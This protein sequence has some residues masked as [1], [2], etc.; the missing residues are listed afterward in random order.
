MSLC[1]SIQP[2]ILPPAPP[3][4]P[5]PHTSTWTCFGIVI[6]F[7][8]TL[9]F[10]IFMVLPKCCLRNLVTAFQNYFSSFFPFSQTIGFKALSILNP[11]YSTWTLNSKFNRYKSRFWLLN[12]VH[13]GALFQAFI[14]N[15]LYWHILMAIVKK[16]FL[17]NFSPV[18][19]VSVH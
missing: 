10:F 3:P 7:F 9:N 17:V 6:S 19:T 2:Q 13:G 1:P 15:I 5:P 11:S 16:R 4:L 14:G 18:R 12:C 8:L